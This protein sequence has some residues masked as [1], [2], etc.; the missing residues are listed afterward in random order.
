MKKLI[1]AFAFVLSL[2]S[3]SKMRCEYVFDKD[4]GILIRDMEIDGNTLKIRSGN[5]CSGT[6][7]WQDKGTDDESFYVELDWAYAYYHPARQS[8]HVY[9]GKNATGHER[10]FTV[11][12][13][14]NGKEISYT[15]RQKN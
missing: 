14:L 13:S 15:F 9:V 8:F 7:W 11:S 1:L 4:G 2:V 12:G 3:C 6:P 5:E 10:Y